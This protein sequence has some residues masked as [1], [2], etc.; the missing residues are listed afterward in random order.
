M[1][2]MAEFQL[3]LKAAAA[4]A[5]VLLE[6]E[7]TTTPRLAALVVWE[8]MEVLLLQPEALEIQGHLAGVALA[9]ATTVALSALVVLGV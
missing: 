5:V 3:A 2:S 1:A 8:L 6:L 7:Q 4:V 9:A